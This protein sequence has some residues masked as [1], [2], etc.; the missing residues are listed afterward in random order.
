MKEGIKGRKQVT[1]GKKGTTNR[2]WK[3]RRKWKKIW[4]WSTITVNNKRNFMRRPRDWIT[5]L[6]ILCWCPYWVVGH[7]SSIGPNLQILAYLKFVQAMGWDFVARAI[8]SC[9]VRYRLTARGES[10]CGQRAWFCSDRKKKLVD[11]VPGSVSVATTEWEMGNQPTFISGFLGSL[12][13]FLF[14]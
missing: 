5:R 12:V 4:G 1:E 13:I 10:H 9:C 3:K 8:Y 14:D 2:K 11:S 7:E 6:S